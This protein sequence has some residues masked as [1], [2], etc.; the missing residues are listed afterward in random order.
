M[1]GIY[2]LYLQ[3]VASQVAAKDE[4]ERKQKVTEERSDVHNYFACFDI[5]MLRCA[6]ASMHEQLRK[7]WS[8][9]CRLALALA[10]LSI[11]SCTAVRSSS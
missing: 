11:L 5:F 8:S 10:V 4:E 6:C 1:C 9:A 3:F 7:Q 2:I